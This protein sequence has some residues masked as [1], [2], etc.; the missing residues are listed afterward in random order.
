MSKKKRKSIERAASRERENAGD[1]LSP[2]GGP[3]QTM[4]PPH[5]TDVDDAKQKL[6]KTS[7]KTPIRDSDSRAFFDPSKTSSFEDVENGFIVDVV[8]EPSSAYAPKKTTASW[9]EAIEDGFKTVTPEDCAHWLFFPHP[10]NV[11]Q[12]RIF[13]RKCFARK[14]SETS[15]SGYQD[16]LTSDDIKAWLKE[17]KMTYG[18]NVDVT[19]YKGGVRRTHNANDGFSNVSKTADYETVMKRFEEDGCSIRILHP[20]RWSDKLWALLSNLENFWQSPTGC[21]AYW[22][23]ANSQGFAPHWDD[24]DAFVLQIEGR[25][26]WR[27][28]PTRDVSEKFPRF[29]SAEF[30]K[31]ERKRLEESKYVEIIL[32]PGDLMYMPRGTI[33]E[34]FCIANDD[35][36]EGKGDDEASLHLTISVNQ[37]NTFADILEHV[38]SDALA[39]AVNTNVELRRC[40]PRDFLRNL[41]RLDETDANFR[42]SKKLLERC[43]NVV[44]EN[45]MKNNVFAG[46]VEK[47]LGNLMRERVRPPKAHTRLT[48][49]S[50]G[51]KPSLSSK[52]GLVQKNC[53]SLEDCDDGIVRLRTY[54][55]NDRKLH[56]EGASA[57]ILDVNAYREASSCMKVDPEIE[58]DDL[59]ALATVLY[60]KYEDGV[61]VKDLPFDTDEEKIA[62]GRRLLDTN[63]FCIL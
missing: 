15:K 11:F 26:R 2:T 12:S 18:T 39:D 54:I 22:T 55:N 44:V 38:F 14:C 25:K 20:Q 32:E 53:A 5:D 49:A 23:P 62:F 47:L 7:S 63:A 50:L 13:E 61:E 19:S 51:A 21:N 43:C 41:T 8:D 27:L 52:I 60:A 35:D 46:S 57:D 48:K 58:G 6:P 42:S 45:M 24:I 28:Y 56:M 3:V 31:E 17:K 9:T 37:R 10:P 59:D 1:V 40:P 36:E 29:S 33:H 4:S 30:S 34:A 16:L